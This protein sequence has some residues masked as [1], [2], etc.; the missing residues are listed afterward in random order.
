MGV[1]VG[2]CTA[3]KYTG[4]VVGAVAAYAVLER[5]LSD[6]AARWAVLLLALVGLGFTVGLF[7]GCPRCAT[8]P[9]LALAAMR[10]H[11]ANAA[12]SPSAFVNNWL[13]PG[14]GWIGT[15]FVYQLVAALPYALGWPLYLVALAGVG[16]AVRRRTTADRIVLVQLASYLLAIG[17]SPVVF[18]RYVLPLVPGLMVLAGRFAVETSPRPRLRRALVVGAWC[19]TLVLATVQVSRFSLDQQ[20]GVVQWLVERKDRLARA[21]GTLRIAHPTTFANYLKLEDLLKAAGLAPSPMRWDRWFEKRPEVIVVS[22][23]FTTSIRRDRPRGP[24]KRNLERLESGAAG[25]RRAASWR[26]TYPGEALYTALDPS[27]HADLWQGEVGFTIY[28][29][30]DVA[31]RLASGAGSAPAGTSEVAG[32]E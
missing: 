26:S 12:S 1:A 20:K 7:L 15:P 18:P 19:Y 16:L 32:A 21:D 10:L 2:L 8:R 22:D 14:L 9:D 28:L 27:F 23:W 31:R 17:W 25:Y 13:A 4:I 5:Y 24:M 3:A 6:R 29:R 30:N 11:G